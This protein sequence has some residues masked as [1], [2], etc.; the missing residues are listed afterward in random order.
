MVSPDVGRTLGF[1]GQEVKMAFSYSSGFSQHVHSVFYLIFG[2]NAKLKTR[3]AVIG[4]T[5]CLGK[6]FTKNWIGVTPEENV[7]RIEM[8]GSKNKKVLASSIQMQSTSEC[9]IPSSVLTESSEADLISCLHKAMWCF[10]SGVLWHLLLTKAT[11]SCES[12][13]GKIYGNILLRRAA[14]CLL[15]SQDHEIPSHALLAD[16]IFC[17]LCGNVLFDCITQHLYLPWFPIMLLSIKEIICWLRD[18]YDLA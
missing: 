5:V 18:D 4:S 16:E 13:M 8:C 6:M 11:E 7:P 12:L 2:V 10:S 1:C 15:C 9:W 14:S 17:V 3:F